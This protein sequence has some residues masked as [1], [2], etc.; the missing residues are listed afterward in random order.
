MDTLP[1]ETLQ[2]IF[3]YACTDGGSTGCS[4]SAT[5]RAARAA[6][7]ASR[8]HSVALKAGSADFQ[9]LAALLSLYENQCLPVYGDRPRM[10]HLYLALSPMSPSR[11]TTERIRVAPPRYFEG[12]RALLRVVSANLQT[13]VIHARYSVP[14]FDCTFPSLK[15]V[16]ALG[17]LNPDLLIYDEDVG[18]LF[19]SATHL[20]IISNG[21]AGS[22]LPAWLAHAPRA[23]RVRVSAL[24]EWDG[25]LMHDLIGVLGLPLGSPPRDGVVEHPTTLPLPRKAVH[26]QYIALQPRAQRWPIMA[27]VPYRRT[28][29]DLFIAW[30]KTVARLSAHM[31]LKVEYVPPCEPDPSFKE[32]CGLVYWQWVD[33][34]MG[35]S[36]CWEG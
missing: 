25:Q 8:F 31:G 35:G 11:K 33:R 6:A 12:I 27:G 30:L 2:Q 13:L 26:L 29:S 9:Q 4:L 36:G 7:H 24:S 19:P 17:I 34:M 23:T 15:E 14:I 10:M 3:E 16:T 20:H 28:R 5:S 1:L 32:W 22:S 18:P 21:D